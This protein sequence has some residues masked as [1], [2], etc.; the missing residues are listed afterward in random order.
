MNFFTFIPAGSDI[1]FTCSM[2]QRAGTLHS[3]YQLEGRLLET[4]QQA[5][6]S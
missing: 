2:W 5:E 6:I 3:Q 1:Y 4:S